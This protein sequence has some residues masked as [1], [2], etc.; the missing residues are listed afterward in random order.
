[1]CLPLHGQD[2]QEK[3]GPLHKR[4][5]AIGGKTGGTDHPE[6]ANDLCN[7]AGE[8]KDQVMME[9][10]STLTNRIP[11][12]R[13]MLRRESAKTPTCSKSDAFEMYRM[14]HFEFLSRERQLCRATLRSRNTSIPF[15]TA[16]VAL[17]FRT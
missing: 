9:R 16:V 5:V 17:P 1:M 13:H 8:L 4:S 2:E 15:V 11:M 10:D 12:P 6:A 7:R 14:I 3:G